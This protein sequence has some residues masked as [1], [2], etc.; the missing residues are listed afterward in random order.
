MRK[1]TKTAPRA[2]QARDFKKTKDLE[3]WAWLWDMGTGKTW[4][5][6]AQT[7]HSYLENEIDAVLILAPKGMYNQWATEWDVHCMKGFEHRQDNLTFHGARGARF[8]VWDALKR[9]QVAYGDALDAFSRPKDSRT[10]PGRNKLDVFIVNT[11]TMSHKAGSDYVLKWARAR[12]GR[13]LTVVDEASLIKNRTSKMT[14]NIFK[15]R[16]LSPFRRVLSGSLTYNTPLDLYCPMKFIEPELFH[17]NWYT[18]RARYAYLRP[19]KAQGGRTFDVETGKYK[20]LEELKRTIAPFHSRYLLN[21]CADVPPVTYERWEFDMSREQSKLYSKMRD[22]AVVE[23]D[24]GEFAS[25]PAVISQI[26]KLQQIASGFLY[27]EDGGVLRVEDNPREKL[28]ISAVDTLVTDKVIIWMN[29]RETMERIAELFKTHYKKDPRYGVQ[30]HGGVGSSDRLEAIRAFN[31]DPLCAFF[32]VTGD[33]GKYGLNLVS[34]NVTIFYNTTCDL[35]ARLQQEARMVRS[36]Q[37]RKTTVL[38]IVA[39]GTLEPK[40]LTTLLRKQTVSDLVTGDQW[41]EWIPAT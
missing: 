27:L 32:F 21:D 8:V 12:A 15:L 30:Y 35:D 9:K 18:F 5:G 25:A 2:H 23:L 13:L 33:T 22:E 16:E 24:S 39:R 10:L 36:G 14:K 31:E 38:D 40:L 1:V 26:Q 3:G 4:M 37:K 34:P 41:R 28:L 6:V 11:E 7:C 20:N 17:S 29:H 19:M